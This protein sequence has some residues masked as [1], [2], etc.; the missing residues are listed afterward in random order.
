M[1]EGH[2]KQLR[3]GTWLTAV[4]LDGDSATQINLCTSSLLEQ[5]QI[6]DNYSWCGKAQR[7]DL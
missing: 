1:Q 7:T 5:S 4:D 3:P 6:E 2:W